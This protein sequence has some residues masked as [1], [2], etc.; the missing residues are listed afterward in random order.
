MKLE[1]KVLVITGGGNG[2]GRELVLQSLLRGARVAAVDVR[3]DSLEQLASAAR[4]GDRLSTHVLD[5]TDRAAVAA[6]PA[7]VIARH[8]SVDGLINNAGIIQPFAHISALERGAIDRVLRVNL[9]G[10]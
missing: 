1:N 5:I 10:T 4:A 3:A 2:I 7:H 6:L 8:G 9:D